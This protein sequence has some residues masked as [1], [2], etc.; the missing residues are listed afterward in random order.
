MVRNIKLLTQYIKD[1]SFEN[2]AAQKNRF[3]KEE[4]KIH[5]DMK[6]KSK[7]LKSHCLE[8]TMVCLL[9]AKNNSEKLFLIELTYA[10]TFKITDLEDL[11]QHTHIIFVDCPNIMFPFVRQILFNI[12]RDS[13][14]PPI[15]LNHIDF[16]ALFDR[17]K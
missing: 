7:I 10:A 8:V 2:Y 13:G 17:K 1:L 11:N 14:F 15:N 3:V 16:D 6:I 4:P 5:I 12:T 9:E